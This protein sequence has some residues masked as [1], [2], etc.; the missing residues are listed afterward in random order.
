MRAAEC[1]EE[2]GIAGEAFN[3]SSESPTTVLEMVKVIRRI[4]NC[5]HIQ[6]DVRNSAG[7]EIRNQYLSVSKARELLEWKPLYDLESSLSETISWYRTFL[8][9]PGR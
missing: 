8:G 2:K 4:M 1:L 9:E 5:E 7:G 6:P 3:F